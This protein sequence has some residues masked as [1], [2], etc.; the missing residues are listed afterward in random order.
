MWNTVK[1]QMQKW[2]HFDSAAMPIHEHGGAGFARNCT[3]ARRDPNVVFV[4]KGLGLLM[5]S[6]RYYQSRALAE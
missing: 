1:E 3:S 4:Q 6:I 5:L 2:I